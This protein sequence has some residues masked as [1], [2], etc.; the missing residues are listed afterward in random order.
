MRY[1]PTRVVVDP[2]SSSRVHPDW[3]ASLYSEASKVPAVGESVIAVQPDQ[4]GPD[5]VG[6]AIVKLIDPERQIIYLDVDWDSFDDEVTTVITNASFHATHTIG[7]RSTSVRA[8]SARAIRP[9]R[10]VRL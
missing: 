10:L 6:N 9:S 4:G 5:F 7:V 2:N 8:N 3:V 1:A